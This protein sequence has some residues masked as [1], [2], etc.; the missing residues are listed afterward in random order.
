MLAINEEFYSIQGEGLHTGV[1]MYF[2]RLQG[3]SVGCYFCDTKYTWKPWHAEVDEAKIVKRAIESK[4]EWMCITGGEP[5]EQDIHRLLKLAYESKLKTHIETSGAFPLKD[6]I[7]DWLCLSPKDLFSKK[8]TL[9]EYKVHAN[10]IKV[11][12]TKPDDLD[13]YLQHYYPTMDGTFF[14]IQPVDSKVEDK[15]LLNYIF[16]KTAGFNNIRVMIQQHKVLHVR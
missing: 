4:A 15:R 16:E 14:I 6:D 3:C 2:V 8:K 9:P 10:E 7:P 1:P 13:Y 12:V 11:V 5:Y